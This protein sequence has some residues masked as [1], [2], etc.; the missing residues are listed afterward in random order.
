MHRTKTG[1][2]YHSYAAKAHSKDVYGPLNN[3]LNNNDPFS[4]FSMRT[5]VDP[6]KG[7]MLN[8]HRR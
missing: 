7:L 4:C 3:K 2:D 6:Q 1:D 8:G 5:Y